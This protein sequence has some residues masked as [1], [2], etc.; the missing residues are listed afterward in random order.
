MQDAYSDFE[1]EQQR[2]MHRD[3]EHLKKRANAVVSDPESVVMTQNSHE[4]K[5]ER[6]KKARRL[7]AAKKYLEEAHESLR[8]YEWGVVKVL[9]KHVSMHPNAF[10]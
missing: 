6:L 8:R 7:R 1:S 4:E 10:E 3:D 2:N 5:L 9:Y